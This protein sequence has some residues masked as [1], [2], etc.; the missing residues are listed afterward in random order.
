VPEQAFGFDIR[1]TLHQVKLKIEKKKKEASNLQ[2]EVLLL[3][4]LI[5]ENTN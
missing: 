1:Q 2:N 4:Q 5:K 3:K